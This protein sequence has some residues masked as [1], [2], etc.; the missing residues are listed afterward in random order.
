MSLCRTS[1]KTAIKHPDGIELLREI[2]NLLYENKWVRGL[3]GP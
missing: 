1:Q 3:R 2:S